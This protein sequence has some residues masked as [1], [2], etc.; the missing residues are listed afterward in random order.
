MKIPSVYTHT[1]TLGFNVN[2]TCTF[3]IEPYRH[4]QTSIW[5]HSITHALTPIL[6][7]LL[8][9]LRERHTHIQLYN[10]SYIYLISF[11][12]ESLVKP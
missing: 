4:L 11:K 1:C 9:T 2:G 3:M 6:T 10:N 12:D 7:D 5:M 8:Y